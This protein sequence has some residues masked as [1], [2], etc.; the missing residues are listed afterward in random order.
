MQVT[1][2][3]L[4]E[5]LPP[6]NNRLV[7]IEGA[8]DVRDIINEMV[9]AHQVFAGDY[10]TIYRFFDRG[11]VMEICKRLFDFC[12]ANIS[13]VIE[14]ENYQTTKSPSAIL[15]QGFGDC[16][17]FA[18]FI[19]GV[20]SAIS[21]NT[22]RRIRWRYRFASY[23]ILNPDP[24]HVYVV[25]DDNGQEISVDPVLRYFNDPLQPFY[26]TDKKIKEMPLYRVSGIGGQVGIDPITIAQTALTFIKVFTG[27]QVPNY[28]IG[29]QDTLDKI[30]AHIQQ[31][32]PLPPT[33]LE[34]A[35][36][37]LIKATELQAALE[38]DTDNVRKTY[39]LIYGEVITALKN[40]IAQYS[41]AQVDPAT[42]LPTTTA[43]G[44]LFTGKNLLIAGGVLAAGY[45]LL[46]KKRQVSGPKV[47]LKTVAFVIGGFWLLGQ[48]NKPAPAPVPAV[49]GTVNDCIS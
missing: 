20:L 42:G 7:L 39:Y 33:S 32:L 23:S 8:Q 46:R 47:K 43:G 28:P 5:V 26:I 4:L 15:A 45:F 14:G 30:R 17:H 27:D 19:G 35:K 2:D 12:R 37:L 22:G 29:S 38:G 6:F 40:Y 48:L 49:S 24:G 16:K 36:E 25:V 1:R 10:D 3:Q 11:T 31:L 18:S 13:Y 41:T 21:R 9:Q 34:N 44:G